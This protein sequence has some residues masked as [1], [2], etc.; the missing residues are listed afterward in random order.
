M[1]PPRRPTKTIA[2]AAPLDHVAACRRNRPRHAA[3][4]RPA[5]YSA[6]PCGSSG[7]AASRRRPSTRPRRPRRPGTREIRRG[8]RRPR[9]R[10]PPRSRRRRV[11]RARSGYSARKAA[12]TESSAISPERRTVSGSMRRACALIRTLRQCD[13]VPEICLASASPKRIRNAS[14][15]L[16][17]AA[18]RQRFR[19]RERAQEDLQAAVAA[20]VVERRPG[21][22]RRGAKGAGQSREMYARPSSAGRWCR[23]SA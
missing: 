5:R 16:A 23:K 19:A 15:A 1:M 21:L 7:C 12:S 4:A 20:N 13:G 17:G 22:R 10:R 11:R 14:T 6:A 18:Q 8:R 2:I 3:A 9:R